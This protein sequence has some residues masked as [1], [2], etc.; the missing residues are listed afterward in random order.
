MSETMS[1]TMSEPSD[2]PQHEPVSTLADAVRALPDQLLIP[3]APSTGAWSE[4][5]FTGVTYWE[6]AKWI[7]RLRATN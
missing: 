1:E 2:R 7:A 3:Y 6:P 4:R 5:L